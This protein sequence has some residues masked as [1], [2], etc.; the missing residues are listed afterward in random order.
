ML[1]GPWQFVTENIGDNPNAFSKGDWK[2]KLR[3]IHTTEFC[4][5]A[6]SARGICSRTDVA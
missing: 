1:E 3:S 4:T 5:V 2:N 6:K